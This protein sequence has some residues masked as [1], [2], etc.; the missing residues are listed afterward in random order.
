MI[1]A[2]I[3][4]GNK[5]SKVVLMRDGSV[6]AKSSVLTGF[7]QRESALN[8]FDA[9]V[10][11][12]GVERGDIEKI[13]ATGSGKGEVEFASSTISDVG[14]VARGVVNVLPS[15]RMVIDVGAEEGRAIKCNSDG[16][17][18]DFAVNEKCA[19][20][21]GSFVESMARALQINVEDFGPFSLKSDKSIAMSAQC[22]VFAESEVVSL[23]HAKTSVEDITRAVS[24]AIASR[25]TSMVRRIGVEDGLALVGGVAKNVGLVR[26]IEN[27]LRK[28]LL[29]PDDPEYIVAL[30][31]A[32]VAAE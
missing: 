15:V 11:Q 12:A 30:G 8:A 23:I 9:A 17:V 3:D 6:I 31:A 13:V 25:I 1:V 10:K 32:L 28:T 16:K 4:V 21:A 18:V 14:A 22:T 2:G 19:A 26:S 24:D 5:F 20:G 27:D 29:I 7:D